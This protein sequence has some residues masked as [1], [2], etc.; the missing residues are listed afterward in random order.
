LL[1]LRSDDWPFAAELFAR[2][3]HLTIAESVLA[4]CTMVASSRS[5]GPGIIRH[6][7]V[8]VMP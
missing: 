8:I 5:Y 6:I 3:H 7:G 2:F 4:L 1:I